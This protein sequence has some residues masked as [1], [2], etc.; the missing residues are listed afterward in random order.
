MKVTDILI[1][2]IAMLPA[3]SDEPEGT[4][5]GIPCE[6]ADACAQASGRPFVTQRPELAN[7]LV[8][9]YAPRDSSELG[10]RDRG[11]SST[12]WRAQRQW[13]LDKFRAASATSTPTS[14]PSPASPTREIR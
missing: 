14:L 1:L 8:E 11:P 7:D 10:A 2:T 6:P 5:V 3:C 13:G 12:A 9:P 4:T